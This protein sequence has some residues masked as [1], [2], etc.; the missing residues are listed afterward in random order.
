MKEQ[1]ELQR[2]AAED[3]GMDPARIELIRT[4]ARAWVANGDTP[5]LVLLVARKG[6]IVLEEAY[7]ILRASDKA[8]LRTD[9]IFPVS[10]LSKTFTAAATLCLV[11]DG[12]VVAEA[13]DHGCVA[14]DHRARGGP[15]PHRRPVDAHVGLRRL[16]RVSARQASASTSKHRCRTRRR[17]R[18]PRSIV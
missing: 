10:S 18:I 11:E 14:G 16:R 9:S 8:P 13:S 2:G 6:V 7:G 3:V 1:L 4:R 17:A 15:G 5:S 12:S